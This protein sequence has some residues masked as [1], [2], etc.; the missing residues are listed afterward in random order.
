[1]KTYKFIFDEDEMK[2]F[3]NYGILPLKRNEIY[4]VS[5][6]ARNKQ[7]DEEERKYYQVGRSEMFA[8]QQIRH[9]TWN[10]FLKHIK[11]F[12]V[13]EDAYLTKAG[14][15]YPAKV[16]V[17]YW[18]TCA[19]DAYKAMKDQ[20]NYLT[21]ILSSLADSAIKNSQGGIDEAFYKVR[22]SFDTCQSLFARNFGTKF[23]MDFDVDGILTDTDCF[24]IRDTIFNLTACN[25]GDIMI[26]KTAGGAHFLVKKSVIHLNPLHICDAIFA[27]VNAKEVIHN[28]NEMIP[29]PGSLMYGHHVV[30]ILNK[31]D[32]TNITPFHHE[33]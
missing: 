10:E 33:G 2:F 13:R 27:R 3:W 15:P 25:T 7:L 19:V 1:M 23:W 26:V 12:E 14:I 16:L 4:F 11:R 5:L 17:C 20:M 28:K 32:F 22:K 18:N 29:L 9:D 31:E 6:S 30:K 8:K 21:E 24:N